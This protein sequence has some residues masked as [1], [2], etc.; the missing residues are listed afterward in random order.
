MIQYRGKAKSQGRISTTFP[1]LSSHNVEFQYWAQ[2]SLSHAA[3]SVKDEQGSV[4]EMERVREQKPA[5]RPHMDKQQ[6]LCW[7][8]TGRSAR[9]PDRGPDWILMRSRPPLMIICR[10]KHN[11]ATDEGLLTPATF[12]FIL[13]GVQ[14]C[15]LNWSFSLQ[16]VFVQVTSALSVHQASH[17]T[18]L[19]LALRMNWVNWRFVCIPS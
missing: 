3:V 14:L 2:R 4:P 5:G 17:S 12:W 10:I 6:W 1:L 18:L 16:S 7:L 15:T 19:A 9:L 13:P 11:G 8:L